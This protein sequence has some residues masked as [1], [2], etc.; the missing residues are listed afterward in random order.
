MWGRPEEVL[1][2]P[3]SGSGSGPQALSALMA[4]LRVFF[5]LARKL[6]LWRHTLLSAITSLLTRTAETRARVIGPLAKLE[7][8]YFGPM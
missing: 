4:V 7:M 8:G 6:V 3:L 5:Q 1:W 2:K